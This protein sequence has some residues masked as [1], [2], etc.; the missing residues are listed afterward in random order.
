MQ[1]ASEIAALHARHPA[2]GFNRSLVVHLDLSA[3]SVA[4]AR[5]VYAHAHT[6]RTP[7]THRAHSKRARCTRHACTHR[8]HRKDAVHLDLRRARLA[9]RGLLSTPGPTP[10]EDRTSGATHP[11]G[12]DPSAAAHPAPAAVRGAPGVRVRLV[13]GS[14]LELSSLDLGRFDY[15]NCVGVLHHLPGALGG[16]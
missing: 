14:L 1:L 4:L 6:M 2:C 7:C 5:H 12:A 10:G 9:A 13:R 8:V 16:P 3:S 11:S 15:V